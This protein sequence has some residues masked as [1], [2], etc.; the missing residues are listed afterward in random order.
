MGEWDGGRVGSFCISIEQQIVT[1]VIVLVA[2]R[3]KGSR[4]GA[5]PFRVSQQKLAQNDS[6]R[7]NLALLVLTR[8]LLDGQIES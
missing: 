6:F 2:K 5:N 3:G 8:G 1:D 7:P 4:K